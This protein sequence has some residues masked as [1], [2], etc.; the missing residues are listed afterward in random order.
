MGDEN[1]SKDDDE[2]KQNE[3]D[4]ATLDEIKK[5][6]D[7]PMSIHHVNM[8]QI[9]TDLKREKLLEHVEEDA[10]V[11]NVDSNNNTNDDDDVEAQLVKE[12]EI[13]QSVEPIVSYENDSMIDDAV[14]NNEEEENENDVKEE[15]VEKD[16]T[17]IDALYAELDEIDMDFEINKLEG[18]DNKN[19]NE[20]FAEKD[21]LKIV[22]DESDEIMDDVQ[23]SPMKESESNNA[24]FPINPISHSEND[25]DDQVE[26]E[27]KGNEIESNDDDNMQAIIPSDDHISNEIV[28]GIDPANFCQT[29]EEQQDDDDDDDDDDESMDLTQTTPDPPIQ[30]EED[31]TNLKHP[32]CD[33]DDDMD[34]IQT[35]D[36]NQ[37]NAQNIKVEEEM[38]E[39]DDMHIDELKLN[40][41]ENVLSS[42][43]IP[44]SPNLISPDIS[45]RDQRRINNRMLRE[46]QREKERI[47]KL[48]EKQQRL[49]ERKKI[50]EI[51]KQQKDEE[52]LK[53][54]KKKKKKKKKK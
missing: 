28:I 42:S 26:F 4:E 34:V 19:E 23:I 53:R 14:Y 7:N 31:D 52:K 37:E 24:E 54:K 25:E 15:V 40:I 18:N 29:E 3:I 1:E 36:E 45:P 39:N 27:N 51:Q 21:N 38:K 41:K 8:L 22:V 13:E 10:I 50:K 2:N 5:S 17:E 48:A 32:T 49:E 35:N 43:H 16:E 20:P 6:I 47:Q 44:I 30:K 11:Q 33:A 12:D 46:E 9:E